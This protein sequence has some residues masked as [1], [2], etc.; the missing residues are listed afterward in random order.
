MDH[1]E[2]KARWQ[3]GDVIAFLSEASLGDGRKLAAKP[4]SG[5]YWND[6]FRVEGEGIDWVVKR[7]SEVITGTL[8]PN[9]PEAEA[10]ALER[11][12]GLEVAPAPVAFFPDSGAGA[13]LVYGFHAGRAWAE[14]VSVVADA[15]RRQHTVSPEGF[16]PVP[17]DARRHHCGRRG[18]SRPCPRR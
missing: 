4:L 8:F 10:A 5:G 3:V 15:M 1:G 16:R 18:H 9:L 11:L 12:D 17:I 2:S 13:V 6:V 14:D 7:F